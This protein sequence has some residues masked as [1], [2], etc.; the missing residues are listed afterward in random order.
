MQG[1]GG[2]RWVMVT[3]GTGGIGKGLI[4]R[5]AVRGENVIA[6]AREPERIPKAR[7]WTGR[8]GPAGPRAT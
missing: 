6:T 2:N 5:L 3:G 7:A 8:K 1:Q 4:A